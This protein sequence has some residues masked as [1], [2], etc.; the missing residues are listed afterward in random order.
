MSELESNKNLAGVGS[1]LL[2][3]SFI[4]IIGIVGIILILIGMKGLAKHY[5]DDSIYHNALMGFIFTVIGLIAF[6]VLVVAFI[7][8]VVA[9][10]FTMGTS[11]FFGVGLLLISGVVLFV[12]YLLGALQFKKAFSTLA[13]KSGEYTFETAGTILLIGAVLTI[14]LI[15]IVLVWIAWI[16]VAIAFFSMKQPI[17]QQYAYAAPPATSSQPTQATR[18]C[19]YCGASNE[20]SAIYCRHCG[21]QLT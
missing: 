18:Y 4:P 11:L 21:K 12:F 2:A 10:P 1:I 17:Q 14:I 6:A 5:Q 3:L 13:Q 8:G 19:S 16:I 15:G 20:A 7:I 9:S